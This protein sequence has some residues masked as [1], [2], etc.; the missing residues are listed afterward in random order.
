[1]FTKNELNELRKLVEDGMPDS[2]SERQRK[3]V[4]DQIDGLN[5]MPLLTRLRA[6]LDVD[7]VP[8]VDGEIELLSRVR[9][10][11]NGV[12]HGR[13]R[14]LPQAEDVEYATSIVARMLVYR[15]ACRASAGAS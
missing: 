2:F 6:V 13:G 11:P 7:S 4:L 9:K 8:Y 10:L 15:V 14:E 5:D 3:R 12:V 1:M